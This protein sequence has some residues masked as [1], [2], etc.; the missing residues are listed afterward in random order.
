MHIDKN[1]SMVYNNKSVQAS[2]SV[3]LGIKCDGTL[4]NK[5]KNMGNTGPIST[6]VRN[7]TARQAAHEIATL[8]IGKALVTASDVDNEVTKQ[9]ECHLLTFSTLMSELRADLLYSFSQEQRQSVLTKA[10]ERAME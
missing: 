9:A 5:G 7:L 1:A 3:H 6:T 10:M 4:L 2:M 8:I